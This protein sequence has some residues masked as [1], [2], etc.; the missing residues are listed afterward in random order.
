MHL[1][2]L[3][4]SIVL[5]LCFS[6][7]PFSN[8]CALKVSPATNFLEKDIFTGQSFLRTYCK[9]IDYRKKRE[10]ETIFIEIPSRHLTAQS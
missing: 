8:L 10:S 5:K 2:N 1:Q 9:K 3:Y 4:Q 6:N 7:F